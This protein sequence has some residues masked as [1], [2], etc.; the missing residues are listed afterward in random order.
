MARRAK[1][2]PDAVQER[3][4][5]GLATVEDDVM[6]GEPCRNPGDLIYVCALI[7]DGN[8]GKSCELMT[9]QVRRCD[10]SWIVSQR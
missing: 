8:V 7:G 10:N 1:R 9:L 4:P 2:L 6:E 3:P 5:V